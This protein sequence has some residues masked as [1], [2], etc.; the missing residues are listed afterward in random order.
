LL[1]VKKI[2]RKEKDNDQGGLKSKANIM[3]MVKASE[4]VD[5]CKRSVL[6]IEGYINIYSE[7]GK[8]LLD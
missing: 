5:T 8:R 6:R 2:K 3:C 7:Y 1:Q 4:Y